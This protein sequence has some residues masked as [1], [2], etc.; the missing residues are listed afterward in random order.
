MNPGANDMRLDRENGRFLGVC[1][2]I[3]NWLDLPV[4][5]VRIVFV[6]C[7]LA[8][9]PLLLGYFII[10]FCVDQ[11]FTPDR[12]RDYFSA[13]ETAEHF[14]KLDYRKPIYRNQRNKRIA[15]VCAGIADYLEVSA[16]SVRLVTLLSFFVF[17]PFTFWAYVICWFVFD[18]DP[19]VSDAEIS[20]RHRRRR[21]RREARRARRAERRRQKVRKSYI[22]EEEYQPAPAADAASEHSTASEQ[23]ADTGFYSRK[24]CTEIYSEL[25]LRLREIEAFMT[26]KRFRLHCEINRI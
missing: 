11:D 2:G 21:E 7:V 8:W 22:N 20:A 3:A 25:E 6:I 24:E 14:R 1:A 10:Y 18:P 15:G 12:I 26:S 17:G 13:S 9:P 4:W 16:F 19:H 5:L 23:E